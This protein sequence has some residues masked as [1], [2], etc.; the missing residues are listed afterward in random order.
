[1]SCL[2]GTHSL[3]PVVQV[4][5][6]TLAKFSDAPA[7]ATQPGKPADAR[8]GDHA[9]VPADDVVLH[10]AGVL[11]QKRAFPAAHRSGDPF[12]SHKAGR[13]V[14][15]SGL[16]ELDHTCAGDV[17]AE[18]LLDVNPRQGGALGRLVVSR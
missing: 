17:A 16:Q 11:Q 8:S 13:P 10:R 5:L 12:D 15:P 7:L 3:E 6:G 1:M 2:P 9:P 4:N 14:W 18:A